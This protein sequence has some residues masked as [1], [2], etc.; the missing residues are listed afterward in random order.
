MLLSLGR[1][2]KLD[3]KKKKKMKEKNFVGHFSATPSTGSLWNFILSGKEGQKKSRINFPD[4]CHR[5]KDENDSIYIPVSCRTD[6]SYRFLC[7]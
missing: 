6:N 3:F 2:F 1:H 5:V 7:L 4:S